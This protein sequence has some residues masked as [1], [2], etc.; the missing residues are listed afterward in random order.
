MQRN[1]CPKIKKISGLAGIWQVGHRQR[2][3]LYKSVQDYGREITGRIGQTCGM[4]SAATYV[5]VLFRTPRQQRSQGP[6][7]II[8]HHRYIQR[9]DRAIGVDIGRV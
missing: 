7:D 9:V 6:V 5:S 2:T 1:N 3:L 4:F 8:H